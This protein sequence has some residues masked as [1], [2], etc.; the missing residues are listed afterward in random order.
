MRTLNGTLITELGLT[1]T[2]PG[3]L[4]EIGFSTTLRLSTL[5]DIS[6]NGYTWVSSDIKVSGLKR[7]ERGNQAGSL[8]IGNA[9]LAFG[10]L[11]LNEGIADKSVKVWSVWAGAPS[12]AQLEFDGIGDDADMVGLRVSVK[13]A[14]DARRYAYSPRRFIAP[15]TGFNVLLPAGTKMAIGGTSIVLER[16]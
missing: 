4:V 8:S 9:D 12:Y 14:T 11:L 5:G 6:Y 3:Y 7:D 2:R 10:A 16:R 1:I 15:A 13:L